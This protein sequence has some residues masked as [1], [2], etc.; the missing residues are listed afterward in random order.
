MS[1]D[2][3]WSRF[4]GGVARRLSRLARPPAGRSGGAQTD[5]GINNRL[6]MKASVGGHLLAFYLEADDRLLT[7][8]F[9]VSGLYETELTNYFLNHLQPGSHCLDV[10]ANFGYF[11]CLMARICSQGKV[12]GIEA[13]QKIR[14][15]AQDNLFINNIHHIGEVLHVAASDCNAPIKL[16]RRNGRSGNTSIGFVDRNYTDQLGETPAEPFMVGGIMIDSLL[17]RLAGRVD[18]MKVDVEGAEPL[19]FRGARQTISANPQLVIVMEWSPGQIR[20]AGFDIGT[21]L[22]EL[23]AMGLRPGDMVGG[24]IVPLTYDDLLNLDYRAGIVLKQGS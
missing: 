22:G 11:S 2:S 10:G 16:Y 18:F 14:D 12:I 19:V 5:G 21:F 9:V 20:H 13:D 23:S 1:N 24:R 8:W 6:L 17:P 15:I 3:R 4:T 7:P